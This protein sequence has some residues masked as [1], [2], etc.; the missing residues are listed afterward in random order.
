MIPM[1]P[2]KLLAIGFLAAAGAIAIAARCPAATVSGTLVNQKGQPLAGR[3]LHLQEEVSGASILTETGAGGSFSVDVPPGRYDLRDQDGPILR[4]G[5]L[6][7][8][9]S[10]INAGKVQEASFP[11]TILQAEIVAPAVVRSPAAITA[12]VRPGGPIRSTPMPGNKPI[13]G[14]PH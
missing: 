10:K 7:G 6:V 13:P 4:S 14:K 1:I 5:V 9:Q 12:Y 8:R 2:H 11:W 3:E